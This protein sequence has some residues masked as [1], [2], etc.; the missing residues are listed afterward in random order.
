MKL[1]VVEY[2]F[3][4]NLI[5]QDKQLRW[6]QP[7]N[8]INNTSILKDEIPDQSYHREYIMPDTRVTYDIVTNEKYDED[9][10][11][12]IS[13]WIPKEHNKNQHIN[14]NPDYDRDYNI[15]SNKYI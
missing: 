7:Y 1:I 13:T 2:F 3:Y 11:S 6:I 5:I 10:A 14:R 9:K 8:I 12:K 15:V 4:Y